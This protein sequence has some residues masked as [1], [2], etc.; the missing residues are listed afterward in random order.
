VTEPPRPLVIG[1]LALQG[2]YDA[3]AKTLTTLGATPRLVR[4]P[5]QLEGLDGLI[6]PGGESTTMLKFL[7]RNKFFDVLETFVRTTP[8]FGTCAGAILLAARVENP[9]QRSLAALD[10]TVERNAYGRQID[11]TILHATTALPGPPLEMVFIR[12]PRITATGPGVEILA[13]R[14]GFPTL[15]RSGNLLA[16][17]FHPELS[18]DPRVHQLFLAI[19]REN[20]ARQ[21]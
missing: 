3:H 19:V 10:I 17:T 9:P 14:D 20:I 11:S 2:A 13:R 12:A 7:D 4:T 5:A 1:V 15:V 6:M 18:R 8:T 16:A 21:V